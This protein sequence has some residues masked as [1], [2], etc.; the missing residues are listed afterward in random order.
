MDRITIQVPTKYLANFC[1]KVSE[2][3]TKTHGGE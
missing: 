2:N 1:Y 3:V